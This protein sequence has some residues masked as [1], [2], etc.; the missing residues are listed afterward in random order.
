MVGVPEPSMDMGTDIVSAQGA[1]GYRIYPP[2]WPI[3]LSFIPVLFFFLLPAR[4]LLAMYKPHGQKSNLNFVFVY[5]THFLKLHTVVHK[6]F[7][8]S[9][10]K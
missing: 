4:L 6:I 3:E 8:T 10:F 1:A 7:R 9:S 5:N 2:G